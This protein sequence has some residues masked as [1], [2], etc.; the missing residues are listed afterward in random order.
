M[1]NRPEYPQMEEVTL[2]FGR[3]CVGE[4][5]MGKDGIPYRTILVPNPDRNDTRPWQSFVVKANHV[6]EN[7]FG[8]GMWCKLPA[9]GSTTLGRNVKVGEDG[10]GK[11]V[12]H[13]E[14]T[15]VTNRELK[16]MMESYKERS[17][18]KEKLS[19]K[20][21]EAAQANSTGRVVQKAGF[22]DAVL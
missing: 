21:A 7:K 2:K 8:R 5:F 4:E 19:E 20:T 12:W 3:G 14:K 16:K 1:E 17:S 15:K 13:L 11:P 10:R 22:K 18:M 9:D 6:H